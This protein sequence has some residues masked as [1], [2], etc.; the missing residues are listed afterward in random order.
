[1][2]LDVDEI[3]DWAE[4]VLLQIKLG[5]QCYT[6]SRKRDRALILFFQVRAKQQ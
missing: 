4:M 3:I 5:L 6:A 1:M 2:K